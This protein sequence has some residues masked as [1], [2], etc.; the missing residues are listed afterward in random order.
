MSHEMGIE[1][2]SRLGIHSEM[3]MGSQ[4]GNALLQNITKR[5][6]AV[7]VF[8]YNYAERYIIKGKE[9]HYRGNRNTFDRE[10]EKTERKYTIEETR[11]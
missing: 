5:A 9:I 2:E 1:E 7:V 10:N 8:C 4:E 6:L 3:H 11:T